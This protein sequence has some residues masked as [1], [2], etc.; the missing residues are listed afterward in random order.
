MTVSTLY[1]FIW[2]IRRVF[3]QLRNASD[4]LLEDIGINASQRAL[5]EVLDEEEGISVPQIAKRLSVSR[6]H[7]QTLVNELLEKGLA[8]TAENPA[9]KR[10]PLVFSTA[11]GKKLFASIKESEAKMLKVLAPNFSNTDLAISMKTLETLGE[12]LEAEQWQPK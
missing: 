5:L 2:K 4:T 1:P 11:S 12:L 3:Q 8:E 7:I 9:H 6:Q 10:S